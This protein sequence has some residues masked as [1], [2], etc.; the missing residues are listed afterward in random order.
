[1]ELVDF[2]KRKKKHFGITPIIN[3]F[4]ASEF[5]ENQIL[6]PDDTLESYMICIENLMV[7]SNRGNSAALPSH[8]LPKSPRWRRGALRLVPSSVIRHPSSFIPHPHP[9]S[10]APVLSVLEQSA[11][12]GQKGTKGAKPQSCLGWHLKPRLSREFGEFLILWRAFLNNL[13]VIYM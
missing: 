7:S 10:F 8:H 1:M 2:F 4:D 6:C 13:T 5:I 9:G 12:Q 3:G 11:A